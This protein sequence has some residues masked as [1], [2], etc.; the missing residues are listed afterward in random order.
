MPVLQVG[1][2]EGFRG[3]LPQGFE[4]LDRLESLSTSLI[5]GEDSPEAVL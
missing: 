3:P 1:A 2:V 5:E 4:R